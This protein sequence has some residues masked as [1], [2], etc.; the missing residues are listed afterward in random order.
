VTITIDDVPNTGKTQKENYSSKLMSTLDSLNVPVTL[1]VTEGLILKGDN[2]DKNRELL[3]NW[4]S[5]SYTTIG[6][7]STEHSRY[8]AVGLDSFKT[9]VET[10]ENVV[11]DLAK[12]NGK[13][14][15]Y[16]RMPYNDLGKDS[17]EHA[18]IEEYLSSR[19]FKIAPFTVESEDYAFC[20]VYEYYLAQ[21]DS[22]KAIAIARDY[23]N[24]TIACFDFFDSLSL[25]VYGK[26]IKHI[27]LCHDNV[28]NADY[29][30][31]IVSELK[32]KNYEF[33][34]FEEALRDPLYSQ[35]DIY[36]KKWGISWL[37]RWMENQ[38]DVSKY[39]KQEPVD[40]IY[41]LYQKLIDERNKQ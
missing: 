14:V 13:Q 4:M 20:Y 11:R 12:K 6:Y 29:L 19:N 37:Y 35:K 27:Y 8:S 9:D 17:T 21:N 5:K 38:K 36:Y 7:H 40:N 15:E 30:P 2:P 41:P 23:V 16:F 24:M 3:N 28:L 25:K 10:G 32:K 22:A 39:Q 1:F 31:V 34:S 26:Q 33:I 18:L